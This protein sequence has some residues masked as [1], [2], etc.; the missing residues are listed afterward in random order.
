[1]GQ[2]QILEA[3]ARGA[4]PQAPSC[5]PHSAQSQLARARAVVLVTGPH[6]RTPR[7]HS[8][9]VVGPGRTP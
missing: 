3:K 4:R 7:I 8:K 1:M 5:R 2:R 9:W 6:A